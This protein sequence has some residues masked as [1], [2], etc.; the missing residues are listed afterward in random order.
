MLC[1][2]TSRFLNLSVKKTLGTL[3]RKKWFFLPD[4]FVGR[5]NNFSY[6]NKMKG[7]QKIRRLQKWLVWDYYQGRNEAKE[8]INVCLSPTS[9]AE[10]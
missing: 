10:A 4:E 7:R 6:A 8:M 1:F 3:L 9:S 2:S 5:G